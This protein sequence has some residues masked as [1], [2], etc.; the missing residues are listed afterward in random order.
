MKT[1]VNTRKSCY[2]LVLVSILLLIGCTR[3]V[4]VD[5]NNTIYNITYINN[6]IYINDTIPCNVTGPEINISFD[7]SYTL[8][9]IRRIKFLEGQQDKYWNN[10]ECSWE[11]NT[12]NNELEECEEE[13]CDNWNSSCC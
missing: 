8:E 5:R 2:C 10:S 1:K 6:T 12:S 13:L 9:L 11:L 4:V 3:V 7:R